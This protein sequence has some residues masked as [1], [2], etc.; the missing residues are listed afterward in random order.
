MADNISRLTGEL[1]R[2]QIRFSKKEKEEFLRFLEGELDSIGI[3]HKRTMIS[4]LMKHVHLEAGSDDPK[5]VLLAHY[6]TQ[7]MVPFWV[8]WLVRIAGHTRSILLLALFYGLV[9]AWSLLGDSLAG[10]IV[11]AVFAISLVQFFIPNRRTMN[12]NSS[13]VIALLA[14]AARMSME[15]D[16]MKDVRLV[17]TDNEERGLLGTFAL[18][19]RWRRVGFNYKGADIIS[20]DSIGRGAIPVI[21]YN[22][23]RGLA[24]KVKGIFDQTAEGARAVNMWL[25]PFSDAYPFSLH[26]AVNINMMD[27]SLIPGGFVIRNIHSPLDRT[28]SP[29]NIRLVTDAVCRYCKASPAAEPKAAAT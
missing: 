17:F 26:G 7:T 14:I 29:E 5:V 24:E 16:L 1:S 9:Y 10:E 3:N 28:I 8:E 4:W 11:A 18:R 6:D 21:S 25:T 19:H 15:P 12:D 23:R 2:R 13:G 22:F 20:V 27:R